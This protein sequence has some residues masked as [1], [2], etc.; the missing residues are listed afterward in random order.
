MG[1]TERRAQPEGPD[2]CTID[3]AVSRKEKP[4]LA[5]ARQRLARSDGSSLL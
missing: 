1:L 5:A 4:E 3:T 2:D